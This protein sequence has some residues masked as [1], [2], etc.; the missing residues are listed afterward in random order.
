MYVCM[1][2]V[3][4]YV[5]M[6]VYYCLSV[7][8]DVVSCK[9]AVDSAVHFNIWNMNW[10]T[11]SL[12]STSSRS[13][14]RSLAVPCVACVLVLPGIRRLVGYGRPRQL[15]LTVLPYDCKEAHGSN[16]QGPWD[17]IQSGACEMC[18]CVPS[19]ALSLLIRRVSHML[20]CPLTCTIITN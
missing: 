15:F 9:Y 18:S 3:C 16:L 19:P 12:T 10:H 11:S 4:V 20:L 8:S 13:L 14:A 2:F 6:Y 17:S 7:C 1:R 5:C